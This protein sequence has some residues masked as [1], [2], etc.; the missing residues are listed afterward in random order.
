MRTPHVKCVLSLQIAEEVGS[1]V[2][3]SGPR[4]DSPAGK[5]PARAVRGVSKQRGEVRNRVDDG[6]HATCG[7]GVGGGENT[8]LVSCAPA[9]KKK[10]RPVL[11]QKRSPARTARKSSSPSTACAAP[12]CNGPSRAGGFASARF[13]SAVERERRQTRAWRGRGVHEQAGC[14]SWWLWRRE[15]RPCKAD[16]ASTAAERP[17]TTP[18][19]RLTK[20]AKPAMQFLPH[21]ASAAHGQRTLTLRSAWGSLLDSFGRPHTP[22]EHHAGRPIFNEPSRESSDAAGRDFHVIIA[23]RPLDVG[24]RAV[25]SEVYLKASSL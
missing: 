20:P 21:L 24:A 14:C 16:R 6:W 8:A 22:A 25:A 18:R 11:L 1:L 10:E 9:A 3:E 19:R 23:Q 15:K 12:V 2:V 7:E 5:E 13:A 4:R 17:T